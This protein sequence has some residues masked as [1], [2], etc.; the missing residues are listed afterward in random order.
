MRL[1]HSIKQEMGSQW[2]DAY[3]EPPPLLSSDFP[4]LSIRL[5]SSSRLSLSPF[6]YSPSRVKIQPPGN[7]QSTLC[8]LDT[9][10][11][12]LRK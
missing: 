9:M 4:Y 3:R 11:I 2:L 6:P 8:L 5:Q 7:D 12:T 10:H 1:R